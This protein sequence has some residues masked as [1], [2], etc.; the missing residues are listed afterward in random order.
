MDA[1]ALFR[2]CAIVQVFPV[3]AGVVLSTILDGCV[4]LTYAR[5]GA[6][7][8]WFVFI[9]FALA[10]RRTPTGAADAQPAIVR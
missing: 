2:S 1:A 10:G 5:Y 4:N 9:A 3:A 7:F 8:A 6:F